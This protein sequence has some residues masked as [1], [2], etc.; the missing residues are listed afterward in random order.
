VIIS[1]GYNKMQPSPVEYKTKG[2]M[3]KIEKTS[4]EISK[5]MVK[6]G[7]QEILSYTLTNKDNLFKK[8]N[9]NEERIVEIENPTSVNWNVFRNW[10]LPSLMEF[11]SNNQHVDYPQKIF[12]IGNVI[13]I[14]EKQETRTKDVIKIAAAISDSK[15]G[16]YDILAIFDLLMS[17]FKKKYE[18]QKWNHPSFIEGRVAKIMIKNKTVGMIGELHPSIL[19]NWKLEMPV[20]AF[21][22]EISDLNS[23]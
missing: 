22:M 6:M 13:L 15:V 7:M 16:Y 1:Y 14:D 17:I 20:A 8:M 18:L 21:E 12:E 3:L 11:Y 4:D 2:E 9:A 10:L 19:S 5:I 23:L